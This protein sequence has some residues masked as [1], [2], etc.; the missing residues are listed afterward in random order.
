MI[1]LSPENLQIIKNQ[2][3]NSYPLEC[4][5][6][7]LGCRVEAEKN[8]VEVI[9]TENVWGSESSSD[10]GSHNSE[11][12]Q[13]RRYAIAP[14]AM[15]QAEKKAREMKLEII[16]IYHSHPDYPA[17]PSEFDREFAWQE[18][19]Y[20]IISTLQGKA[21]CINSWCLDNNRQFLQE[22]ILFTEV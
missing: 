2:S 12:G 10:F 5:G 14:K 4:C 11:H 20:V 22:A 15:L 7:M 19:S 17:I 6:I 3:E 13:S 16:G 21:D 9:P 1:K 18:Y 8:V